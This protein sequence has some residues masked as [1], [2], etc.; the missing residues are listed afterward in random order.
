MRILQAK[1]WGVTAVFRMDSPTSPNREIVFKACLVPIFRDAPRIAEILDRSCPGNVPRLLGWRQDEHQTWTLFQPFSGPT[2]R[3]VG[4]L[5][6]LIDLVRTMAHVQTTVSERRSELVSLSHLAVHEIPTLLDSVL[7]YIREKYDRYWVGQAGPRAKLMPGLPRVLERARTFHSNVERWT[8][9]LGAGG[10]PDS[11]DHPDLHGNN[12]VI[13]PD[14]HLLIF[15]WEESL[16]TVPFFSLDELLAST[17]SYGESGVAGVR[18]AYLEALPWKSFVQRERALSLALL[19]LPIKK[20]DEYRQLDQ[21]IGREAGNRHLA[22]IL[23]EAVRRWER[24]V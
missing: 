16:V 2:V 20:A 7:T 1:E 9:E 10:W 18:T 6:A 22:L 5:Q 4:T 12:A 15:D 8:D 14:G 19:L 13:Q 24:E 21:A 11:L 23:T 3:S 17:A